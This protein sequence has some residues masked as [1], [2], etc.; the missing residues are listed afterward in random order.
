MYIIQLYYIKYI[1]IIT[2]IFFYFTKFFILYLKN[3]RSECFCFVLANGRWG[4]CS[5]SETIDYT[6]HLW[7][8]GSRR[9]SGGLWLVSHR[10]KIKQIENCV[11]ASVGHVSVLVCYITVDKSCHCLICATAGVPA[12]FVST[13]AVVRA[14]LADVRW[15]YRTWFRFSVR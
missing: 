15:V 9:L 3:I 2:I 14:T 13:W 6:F 12:L 7:S 4:E 1:I 11:P 10:F 8:G 5:E